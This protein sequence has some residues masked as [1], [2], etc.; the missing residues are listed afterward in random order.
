MSITLNH[1]LKPPPKTITVNCPDCEGFGTPMLID[2]IR[3]GE[4]KRCNGKNGDLTDIHGNI[5]NC[6]L[7][8]VDRKQGVNIEDLIINVE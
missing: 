1:N 4:C 5:D 2:S 8:D 3:F 7:S 6:E